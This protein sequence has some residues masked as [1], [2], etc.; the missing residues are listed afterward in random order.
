[1]PA[2]VAWPE[3]R[4]SRWSCLLDPGQ[5]PVIPCI[6]PLV[7]FRGLRHVTRLPYPSAGV[8]AS[9]LLDADVPSLRL[10]A[11]AHL[12]RPRRVAAL[13]ELPVGRRAR[14]DGAVLPAP[15]T[16][17]LRVPARP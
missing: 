1:M 13:R 11:R 9:H 2:R 12:R 5:A 7:R 15:R 17:L 16:A 14:P 6:A 4:L 3:L 10:R 8:A